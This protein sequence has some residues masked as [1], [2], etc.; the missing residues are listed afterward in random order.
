MKALFLLVFMIALPLPL[1]PAR[2]QDGAWIQVQAVRTL[3]EGEARARAYAATFSNVA[4]FRLASGWY[5][6]ALGPYEAAAAATELRSLRS[7][8]LIPADSYLARSRDYGRGQFW[9]VGA[10]SL[11][12]PPS[13][14]PLPTES[15]PL[16]SPGLTAETVAEARVSE[17][18]LTEDERRLLQQSLK[19]EGYYDG[20][21]DGAFG[22]GTR[23]A[24]AAWQAATGHAATGVLS[25]AERKDLTD[26]Y[27]AAAISLVR[28]NEA[29]IE[30]MLP[31]WKL[32]RD[33]VEA[34]FIRYHSTGEH[35]GLQVILISQPGT[36]ARL[37]GLYDVMQTLEI[38]PLEGPRELHKTS[39]VLTGQSPDLNSYTYARLEDGAIKGFALVWKPVDEIY[40]QRLLRVMRDSFTPIPG[41]LMRDST[42]RGES[43]EQRVDLMA[44]LE[45]RRPAHSQSGLFVDAQGMVLTTAEGL[46]QCRRLTIGAETEAEVAARDERFGLALLKPQVPLAPQAVAMFASAIPRLNSDV[47][48]AG[49]SYEDLL[50]LPVLTYGTL[51]DTRSLEGETFSHRL[52]LTALPGDVGGPVFDAAGSVLGMLRVRTQDGRRQLPPDVNFAI[53]VPVILSFLHQAGLVSLTSDATQ[54]IAA[55]D[56]VTRAGDITVRV[57]CWN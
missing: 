37:A 35:E 50:T 6:I 43:S 31:Y 12:A 54:A 7:S 1:A 20:V 2:A 53:N 40:A 8:H 51:A 17:A 33:L 38:V 22:L 29:G 55:E 11:G 44:G 21:I 5:A 34:P 57:S 18:R 10:D 26:E 48:L 15:T 27:R 23:N 36:E 19:W 42:M 45:V 9:P 3:S 14:A 56:L 49:F 46:G 4:G 13:G 25:T 24:M 41:S 39:F 47:A 30:I 16:T 52:D 28:E 32:W